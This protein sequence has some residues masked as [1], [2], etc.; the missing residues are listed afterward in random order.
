[1]GNLFFDNNREITMIIGCRLHGINVGEGD[2]TRELLVQRFLGRIFGPLFEPNF[3]GFR[4]LFIA[5]VQH[6]GRGCM[7]RATKGRRQ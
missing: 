7:T 3:V 2:A 1:M 4:P 6:L 5:R